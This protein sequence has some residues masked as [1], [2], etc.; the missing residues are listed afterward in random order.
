[1]RAENRHYTAKWK[2][3]RKHH[4]ADK[5]ANAK[6]LICHSSKIIGIPS[7]QEIRNGL[8]IKEEMKEITEY[9]YEE[10]E[11]GHKIMVTSMFED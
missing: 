1:M 10:W 2:E 3:R 4:G 6:C 8:T 7:V 9:D 5:C 11:R